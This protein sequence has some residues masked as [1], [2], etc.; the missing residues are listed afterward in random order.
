[1]RSPP[2]PRRDSMIDH[3]PIT[4]SLELVQQWTDEI[5]GGPGVVAASNDICLAKLAA[6]WGADQELEGL[7]LDCDNIDVPV[8]YYGD[9]VYVYKEGYASGWADATLATDRARWGRPVTQENRN[10]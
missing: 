7:T 10:D 2:P 1:M 3:H 4:P 8:W 5:Y 6:Q 9:D